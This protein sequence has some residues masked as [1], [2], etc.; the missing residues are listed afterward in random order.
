VTAAASAAAED[1]TEVLVIGG[2]PAG[3]AA[4]RAL[5]AAGVRQVT[6]VDREQRAGG[7]PRH[8]HHGG[9][10]LRDLHRSMT[11]PHYADELVR[12][13]LAA[14]VRIETETI[15]TGWSGP[16]VL[17]LT[18]PTGVRRPARHRRP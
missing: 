6:V 17:S 4:A 7:V 15:A 1:H 16:G 2:G 18:S 3:L 5:A 14:G 12:R 8:C 13:A 11:G 9:F 10:G